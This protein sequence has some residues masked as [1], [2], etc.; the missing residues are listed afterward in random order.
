MRISWRGCIVCGRLA[1]G[2]AR[3]SGRR[4][5]GARGGDFLLAVIA[6]YYIWLLLE[7]YG[8]RIILVLV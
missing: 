2:I 5:R 4:G 1:R 3:R 6:G 7:G 8:E